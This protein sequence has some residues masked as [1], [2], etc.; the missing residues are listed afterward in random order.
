MT[1][2]TDDSAA[3]AGRWRETLWWVVL[4]SLLLAA[5][6]LLFAPF[7]IYFGNPDEYL[8]SFWQIIGPSWKILLATAAIGWLVGSV[9]P[10]RWRAALGAVLFALVILTWLQSNILVVSYGVLDG[11]E[12]DWTQHQWRRWLD[13]GL[14]LGLSVLVS[15]RPR[16]LLKPLVTVSSLVFLTQ[17]IFAGWTFSQTKVGRKPPLTTVRLP[18]EEL[19]EL[20]ADRNVV[21]LVLDEFS[22]EIFATLLEEDASFVQDLSGFT[23]FAHNTG[24][25]PTTIAALPTLMSGRVYRNDVPL[26][27]LIAQANEESIGKLLEQRGFLSDEV[28]II[29]KF[30]SRQIHSRYVLPRPYTSLGEYLQTWWARMLDHALFRSAP[31]GL[32]KLIYADGQW[33]LARREVSETNQHPAVEFARELIARLHVVDSVPRFKLIHMMLP[34]AP[35]VLDADCRSIG[36]QKPSYE[37]ATIQASCAASLTRQLLQKLRDI[38]IYDDSLIVICSDHGRKAPPK[39][40]RQHTGTLKRNIAGAALAL[41][42]IKPPRASGALRISKAPTSSLD[43]PKTIADLLGLDLDFPGRA[44]FSLSE[45]ES[46]QRTFNDYHWEHRLWEQQFLPALE[47]Y[48]IDGD[49]LDEL[50]WSYRGTL[51]PPSSSLLRSKIDFGT[52]QAL[53]HLGSMG[54]SSSETYHDRDVIWAVGPEAAVNVSLPEGS[55]L[56]LRVTLNNPRFNRGQTISVKVDDEAIGRWI[57]KHNRRWLEL[58]LNLPSRDSRPPV[59]VIRFKFSKYRDIPDKR[60]LAVVFDELSISAS[61]S[62]PQTGSSAEA[63]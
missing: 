30:G 63:L 40:F 28:H 20:S 58:E 37:A 6:L 15:F 48:V 12:I 50:S 61:D 14:W 56:L 43:I 16:L 7:N 23:F 9:L 59:S 21:Y 8:L 35:L 29:P 45:N 10:A 44:A 26:S 4:P 24:V 18:P 39:S 19:F 2:I 54:W 33:L 51:L 11:S 25:F 13:G 34:H 17:L 22:S 5:N 55:S 53:A 27:E 49:P 62:E 57:I 60:K 46:R 32:K 1:E 42:A 41:L 31:H 52:G 47:A 3:P 36:H 38:E